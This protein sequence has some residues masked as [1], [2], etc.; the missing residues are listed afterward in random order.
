MEIKRATSD[1]EKGE[2]DRLLWDV[3]WKPLGFSRD[4][5]QSFKLDKPQIDLIAVHNDAIVGGLVA[6]R[7]SDSE[8]EIRHIAVAP[9]FQGQSV[10][11]GLVKKLIELIKSDTS[12]KI[13][14]YA[15]NTSV[16]FFA[17]LG[18]VSTGED[19]EHPS[20]AKYGIT[21]QQMYLKNEA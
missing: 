12:V 21:F 3:L 13:L 2:L 6:N 10:G 20:F 17:R 11:R 19:L 5:R 18:F 8:V 16:G 15:R 7:L 1:G 9:D 14:T 4:I